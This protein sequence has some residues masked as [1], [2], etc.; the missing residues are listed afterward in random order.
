MAEKAKQHDER[1]WGRF[2][3]L[4]EFTTAAAFP[5]VDDVMIKKIV[6]DP[7][8]R[9]SA[10]MHNLRQEFWLVVQGHGRVTVGEFDWT[11]AS[12]SI[13]TVPVG[14][15]HRIE[16]THHSMQLVFV[17]IATGKVYEDDIL[18]FEDDFGRA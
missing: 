1:P 11:V 7:G 12:G 2:E 3:V 18:R 17:E 16:N 13:V 9:L 15:R 10:Q 14:A 5:D 6:V 4:S 8:K